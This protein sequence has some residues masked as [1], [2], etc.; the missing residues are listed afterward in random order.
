M[1]FFSLVYLS[2][3]GPVETQFGTHLIYVESCNKPQNT[4][5]MLF[6]DIVGKVSG[7]EEEEEQKN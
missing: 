4:W 6:D 5:K 1:S 3:A 2:A 7:K